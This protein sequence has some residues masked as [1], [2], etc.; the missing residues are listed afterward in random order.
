MIKETSISNK[1]NP[2]PFRSKSGGASGDAYNERAGAY[3]RSR[4]HDKFEALSAYNV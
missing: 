3:I 2:K 1:F 4:L